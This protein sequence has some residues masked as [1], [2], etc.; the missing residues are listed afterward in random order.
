[1]IL[2]EGVS[3][4][5]KLY[6]WEIVLEGGNVKQLLSDLKSAIGV[7][8]ECLF[9]DFQMLLLDALQLSQE[10]GGGR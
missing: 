1:T 5:A 8:I 4:D 7:S 3:E 6:D 9:D 2:P 10:M